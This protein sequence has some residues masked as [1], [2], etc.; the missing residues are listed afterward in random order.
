MSV[1]NMVYPKQKAKKIF[2]DAGEP[3]PEDFDE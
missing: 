3:T 2:D 1:L